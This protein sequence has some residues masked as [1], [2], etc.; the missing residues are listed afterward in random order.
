MRDMYVLRVTSFWR[1][2]YVSTTLYAHASTVIL[3]LM[4]VLPSF[5]SRFSTPGQ[6]WYNMSAN[7][8]CTMPA[9]ALRKEG[10]LLF[11]LFYFG[12]CQFLFLGLEAP[13]NFFNVFFRRQFFWPDPSFAEHVY[14]TGIILDMF[15]CNRFLSEQIFSFDV[16]ICHFR[17][18]IFGSDGNRGKIVSKGSAQQVVVR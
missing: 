15:R 16:Q 1:V 11:S 4:T 2:L 9:L 3:E 18:E 6:A 10:F 17:C 13:F 5:K 12:I 8:V 7:R 14:N